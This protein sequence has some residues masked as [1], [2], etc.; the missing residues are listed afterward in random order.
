MAGVHFIAM[1]THCQT[2]DICVKT[3]A[4]R[5]GRRWKV[6]TT[7]PAIR[8]VLE[9]IGRPRKLTFEEG[10]LADWLWRNLKGQVDEAMVCDPRRNALIAKDGD[11]DDPIDANK[12]CDLYLGGYLREVHH[13]ES[14][15]RQVAKQTVGLYHER[16]TQR[17]RAS[18]K[19]LGHL[20]QWG[21]VVRS[22]AL[23]GEASRREL[24]GKL[25]AGGQEAVVS[26]HV[27]LLLESYDAALKQEEV[28]RREV[29]KLAK[30]DEQV[31]RWQE[32]P[33]IGPVR[34]MTLL[35]YLDTPW[36]FKGKS[37]LFK[38]LGIGLVRSGSG[39][40]A[41]WVRV[42]RQVNRRLKNAILGAAQQAIREGNHE[43]AQQYRRWVE[44]GLSPRNAR[45]NVAR[46]LAQVL[47][48]MWKNGGDY[49][50][51]LVGRVTAGDG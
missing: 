45:R 9:G 13:P 24:L 15:S 10:P 30:A 6:P 27:Q 42:E 35:A 21:V 47:W 37:A 11:K 43:F 48:G 12:L 51:K 31:Q 19:V 32:V 34:G 3:R 33:G 2:T 38:Y 50:P 18:N 36:R 5:P 44:A 23:A 41:E 22:G 25:E 40:G 49:D 14:L 8:E 39:Q 4:N 20:R 46:S 7:I 29:A 1:D 28:L 16:V 17:V 26:G